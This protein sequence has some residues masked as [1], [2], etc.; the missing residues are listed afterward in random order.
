[1]LPLVNE[2]NLAA[3]ELSR[4]IKFQTKMVKRLDPFLKDGQMS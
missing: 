1:M 2:A 3:E 4:D